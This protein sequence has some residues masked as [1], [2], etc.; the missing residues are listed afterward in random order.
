MRSNQSLGLPLI[1]NIALLGVTGGLTQLGVG[2]A[3]VIAVVTVVLVCIS[4]THG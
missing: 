4:A 3:P 1:A 2:L